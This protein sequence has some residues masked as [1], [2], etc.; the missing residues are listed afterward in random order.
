M[1]IQ[2][3]IDIR[4]ELDDNSIISQLRLS[5]GKL[6]F[7]NIP[8]NKKFVQL[9]VSTCMTTLPFLAG[10]SDVGVKIEKNN[11]LFKIY[12]AVITNDK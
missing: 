4:L 6:K 3:K 8:S 7:S 1:S 11:R 9:R 5:P 12:P 2:H 10:R